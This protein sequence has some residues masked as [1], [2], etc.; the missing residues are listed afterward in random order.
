M[1]DKYFIPVSADSDSGDLLRLCG[2]VWAWAWA[3]EYVRYA[4][5]VVVVVASSEI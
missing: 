5:T 3:W 4:R 2:V 1:P